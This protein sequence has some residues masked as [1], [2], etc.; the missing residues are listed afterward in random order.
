MKRYYIL[1]LALLIC[2]LNAL[3][4]HKTDYVSDLMTKRILSC[5]DIGYNAALLIPRMYRE[6]KKDTLNAIVSY[7][8]RNCGMTE[9]ASTLSILY[10]IEQNTFNRQLIHAE[11]YNNF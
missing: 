10:S 2:S 9:P 4:Q 5:D 3:A 8:Q 1:S 11:G 7:W 6:K